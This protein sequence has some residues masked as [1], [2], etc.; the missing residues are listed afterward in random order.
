VAAMMSSAMS[1]HDSVSSH[2]SPCGGV[3]E[4]VAS[5][6]TKNL[7]LEQTA[8]ATTKGQ[9]CDALPMVRTFRGYLR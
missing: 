9:R 1:G 8:A 7:A 2:V 5:L 3:F 6:R 4:F